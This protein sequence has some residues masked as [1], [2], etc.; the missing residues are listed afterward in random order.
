[1]DRSLNARDGPAIDANRLAIVRDRL[2]MVAERAAMDAEW[3]AIVA[4]RPATRAFVVAIDRY[5]DALST[6]YVRAT[7]L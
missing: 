2:A 4:E 6:N 1:V 7:S 3:L 5:A